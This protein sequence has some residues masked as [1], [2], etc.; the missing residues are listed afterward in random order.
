[1]TEGN[2]DEAE[3]DEQERPGREGCPGYQSQDAAQAFNGRK[4]CIVLEGQGGEESI[5]ALCRREGIAESLY[6]S[7]SKEFLEAGKKR[8]AGMLRHS[9]P[10]GVHPA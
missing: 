7:W 3:I 4:I 9:K 2:E 5:A 1:M 10:G 6:Y 8:L